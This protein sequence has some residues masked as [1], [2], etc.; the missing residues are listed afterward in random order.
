MHILKALTILIILTSCTANNTIL[1][2]TESLITENDSIIMVSDTTNIATDTVTVPVNTIKHY[3]A[4]GDSYTIGQ[5]VSSE[6]SF[7]AQLAKC[8]ED[9]PEAQIDL[10]IIA[11]TG[12]TTSSLIN[13]IDYGTKRASYDLVTL[14]IGVNNQYQGRLFSI[15]EKEFV[16]LLEKAIQ[17]A[18]NN[19][20]NVIVVSIPDYAYT[21]FGQS[22]NPGKISSEIDQ[23]NKFAEDTANKYGVLFINITDITRQGLNDP[24]LVASDNL[25]P[26]GKAYRKFSE[27]ICPKALTLIK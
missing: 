10:E 7:P 9:T 18:N 11:T 26:S 5:S 6:K 2:E 3:L 20:N 21:P 8:L 13:A 25:H 14:L 16:I 15:Y 22:G 27:R 12:W 17:L 1:P 4:L 19:K 23:Y 24:D